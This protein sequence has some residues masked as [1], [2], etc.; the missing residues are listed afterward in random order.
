MNL[1]QKLKNSTKS[2]LVSIVLIALAPFSVFTAQ[3]KQTL[4]L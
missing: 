3:V 2:I 1:K 4:Q